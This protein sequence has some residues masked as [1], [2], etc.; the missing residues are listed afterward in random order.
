MN[1]ANSMFYSTCQGCMSFLLD[2]AE[3]PFTALAIRS[4]PSFF[5]PPSVYPLFWLWQGLSPWLC[6]WPFLPLARLLSLVL[7]LARPLSPDTLF[8]PFVQI[9]I[10]HYFT[11]VA[12]TWIQ[13]IK[14]Y[15]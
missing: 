10:S 4:S 9:I 8:G 5:H 2:K 1:R 15:Q 3:A 13:M 12:E 11:A 7:P 14:A 6:L